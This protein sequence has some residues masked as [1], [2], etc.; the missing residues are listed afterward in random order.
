ML[1]NFIQVGKTIKM[2]IDLIPVLSF[3][4]IIE[5][6][7]KD[8]FI[9][10]IHGQYAQKEPQIVKCTISNST[11][12]RVCIFETIIRNGNNNMLL[13]D[14]PNKENIKVTQRREYIRV[15][16]DKEVSCYLI[17]INDRRIESDKIF[18]AIVKDISGGGVLLNS[19]LSFP[20]G[21]I[22]VFEIELDDVKFLLTSKVLRNLESDE[23]GTRNLGCQFIGIDNG[24]R[25]KII[26]YCNKQQLI[27]KRR[28]GVIAYT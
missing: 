7:E 23:D 24:Y 20:I 26:A 25:Q 14:T 18:P 12:T 19:T 4:G 13:L 3:K 5:K 11:K 1:D 2:E 8:T 9:V 27:L 15:P 22:L 10:K 6:L 17:E 16:I 28:S 21:T